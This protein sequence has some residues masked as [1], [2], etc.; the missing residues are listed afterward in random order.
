MQRLMMG[1]FHRDV[2]TRACGSFLLKLSNVQKTRLPSIIRR[3]S[4][5]FNLFL[6]CQISPLRNWL[7]LRCN[8]CAAQINMV[9]RCPNDDAR[10]WFL[11]CAQGKLS[12]SLS[13]CNLFHLISICIVTC[14]IEIV[15]VV[16]RVQIVVRIHTATFVSLK[17][18]KR[19]A[20]LTAGRQLA[21]RALLTQLLHFI[22]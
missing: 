3:H 9:S 12:Q 19:K 8:G 2:A 1:T 13:L 17:V 11:I 21:C 16:V 14:Q 10:L 5:Y 20:L 7:Y 6:W 4:R 22:L 15:K 18:L